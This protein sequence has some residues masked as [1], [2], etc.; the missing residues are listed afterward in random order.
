MKIIS[1]KKNTD[2]DIVAVKTNTGIT[3]SLQEAIVATKNYEIEDVMV[4]KAKNGRET[5]KSRPNNE[6][7]DNLSNL[8]TF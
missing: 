2:G 4:G 1:V 7:S 5:L 6:I 8:P 3:M